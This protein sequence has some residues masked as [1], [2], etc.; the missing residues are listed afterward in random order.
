M[1]RYITLGSD[2]DGQVYGLEL[3]EDGRWRRN[4][5]GYRTSCVV[6]RPVSEA[7]D[8]YLT[9]NPW[10]AIDLWKASVSEGKTEKGL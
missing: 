9:K 6:I 7:T 8:R 1:A 3:N 10:S 5:L 2:E 4:P